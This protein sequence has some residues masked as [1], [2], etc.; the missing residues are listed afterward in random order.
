[1]KSD[2]WKVGLLLIPSIFAVVVTIVGGIELTAAG[3]AL[4]VAL[5]A[6]GIVGGWL[7]WRVVRRGSALVRGELP[8]PALDYIVWFV[9]GVPLILGVL[10]VVMGL[11]GSLGQ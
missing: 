7:V 8:S 4:G 1:M 6:I 10:L 11:T 5:I 2:R 9:L 3:R